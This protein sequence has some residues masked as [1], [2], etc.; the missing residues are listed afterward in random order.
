MSNQLEDNLLQFPL[1]Q[2]NDDGSFKSVVSKPPAEIISNVEL[3]ERREIRELRKVEDIKREL[4]EYIQGDST[5]PEEL[6]GLVAC[7]RVL[8]KLKGSNVSDLD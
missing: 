1:F 6:L 8:K 7:V 2:S 5:T 3:E 4:F